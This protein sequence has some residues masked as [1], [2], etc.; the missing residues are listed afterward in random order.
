MIIVTNFEDLAVFF[1]PSDHC[2]QPT[3]ERVSTTQF[4]LTLQII[5]A[6]CIHGTCPLGFWI[7]GPD[8]D[9]CFDLPKG[10]PQ[11]PDGVMLSDDQVN[12]IHQRLS[13]FD[14]PTLL[15]NKTN[16]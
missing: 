10:P 4:S 14:I 8:R 5:T 7:A 13:D 15:R 2:P 9:F 16:R 11:N 12:A 3:F 1:P 6:A